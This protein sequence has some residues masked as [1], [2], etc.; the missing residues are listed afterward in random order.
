MSLIM[1]PPGGLILVDEDVSTTAA[2]S[3][4]LSGLDLDTDRTYWLDVSAKCNDTA[5]FSM[6]ANGLTVGNFQSAVYRYSDLS[7]SASGTDAV[8]ALTL[9]KAIRL[10]GYIVRNTE[11]GSTSLS[12]A[13]L[14][15]LGNGTGV[16]TFA[17]WHMSN[18]GNITSLN[19]GVR[20]G[21]G[22]GG[23]SARIYRLAGLRV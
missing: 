9:G 14:W 19:I 7:L 4:S 8:G 5:M 16:S 2:S 3:I 11:N 23:H 18:T 10:F 17:N 21:A 22:F 20:S 15:C 6:W 12:D 13:I 1:P